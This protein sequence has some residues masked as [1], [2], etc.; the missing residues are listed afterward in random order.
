LKQILLNLMKNGIEA[1]QQ[2][3][4]LTITSSCDEAN[5][6]IMISDTGEGIA[7]E[8]LSRIFDPFFSMK[9][10]GTG[11]GLPISMR[12]VKNH[13]GDLQVQSKLGEGTQFT[14][15]LPIQPTRA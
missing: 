1:M 13:G 11:L 14:I 7:P 4:K 9:E 6:Q 5:V 10:E 3:G 12:M 15:S 8:Y 2:G